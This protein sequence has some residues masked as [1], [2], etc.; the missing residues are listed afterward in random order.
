MK[1]KNANLRAFI[2]TMIIAVSIGMTAKAAE[3]ATVPELLTIAYADCERV[4]F[5]HIASAYTLE[6][7]KLAAIELAAKK[8]RQIDKST[9]KEKRKSCRTVLDVIEQRRAL[10]ILM[11]D[12]PTAKFEWLKFTIRIL[13]GQ[14]DSN[15]KPMKEFIGEAEKIDNCPNAKADGKIT[16]RGILTDCGAYSPMSEGFLWCDNWRAI[17]LGRRVAQLKATRAPKEVVEPLRQ[18]SDADFSCYKKARAD[19]ASGWSPAYEC[20]EADKLRPNADATYKLYITTHPLPWKTQ[21]EECIALKP[22]FLGD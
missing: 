20:P 8:L 14:I 5:L 7:E 9:P 21:K 22:L 15:Q 3:R 12:T 6:A 10:D 17:G 13:E 1:N 2:F 18:A 11:R 19:G 4:E 16:I